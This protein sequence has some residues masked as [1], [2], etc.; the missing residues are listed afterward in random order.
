MSAYHRLSFSIFNFSMRLRGVFTTMRRA[1]QIY[2]YV[3]LT[4]T[5]FGSPGLFRFVLGYR[6]EC[7]AV[8]SGESYPSVRQSVRLSNA[9]IVTK[10][11]ERSVQIFIPYERSFCLVFWQEK[12]LVRGRAT[13]SNWNF[14]QTGPVRAKLPILNRYLLVAPQP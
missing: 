14:G 4:F 9:C 12:W 11:E 1:I 8:W 13:P 10:K 6:A 5:L 7:R 2:V 3:Y